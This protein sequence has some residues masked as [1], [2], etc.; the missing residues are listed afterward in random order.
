MLRRDTARAIAM[1]PLIRNLRDRG[2]SINAIAEELTRLEIKAPCGGVRW[3]WK[4][5]RRLFILAG[6][7]PPPTRQTSRS[8]NR[9][10]RI[11][12]GVIA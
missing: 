4:P 6:D 12:T 1:A 3:S 9:D 7:D 2:K 10:G 11:K 5:V 8:L